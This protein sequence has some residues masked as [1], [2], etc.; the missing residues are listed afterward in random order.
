MA[1]N[2]FFD[3]AQHPQ[4]SFDGHAAPV[5]LVHHAFGDGR[6]LIE[7]FV[8]GVDHHGTIEAG[9]DAVVT[10]RLVPVVEM[11]R[12]NRFR[13]DLFGRANHGF[14]IPLVGVLAR[15]FAELD[16]ERR[17]ALDVALEQANGLLQIVDVIR[18]QGI[19]AVGDFEQLCSGTNHRE[20]SSLKQ[21]GPSIGSG[22]NHNSHCSNT[23]GRV[24]RRQT[25]FGGRANANT[26]AGNAR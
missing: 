9:I 1:G 4:F 13:K 11:H 21:R 24:P 16:D 15:A 3:A 22:C 25:S 18:A 19:L 7:W 10:R 14:Q 12:K 2:V 23:S 6:I 8:A 20:S 5:G 17:L 26:A